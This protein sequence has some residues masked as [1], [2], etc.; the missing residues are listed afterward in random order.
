MRINNICCQSMSYDREI[1][2]VFL[3]TNNKKHFLIKLIE[4]LSI[5]T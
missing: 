4:L 2:D 3:M 5:G 1:S